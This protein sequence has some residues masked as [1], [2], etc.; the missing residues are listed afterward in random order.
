MSHQPKYLL[1]IG[2]EGKEKVA[3]IYV[4]QTAIVFSL[5]FFILVITIWRHYIRNPLLTYK[6]YEIWYLYM[7]PLQGG[8]K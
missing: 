1:N 5:F 2:L 8:I 6:F 3:K 4:P 7:N